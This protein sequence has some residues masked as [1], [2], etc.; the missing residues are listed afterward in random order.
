MENHV[1]ALDEKNL[2][3]IAFAEETIITSSKSHKDIDS[4]LASKKKSGLLESV[5]VIPIK[6][7]TFLSYTEIES[8]LKLKYLKDGKEK[9]KNFPFDIAEERIDFANAIAE[10]LNFKKDIATENKTTPLLKNIG[11]IAFLSLITYVL[12]DAATTLQNGGTI[13]VSGRRSGVKRLFVM[14]ADY[15]GPTGSIIAGVI[16]I[17]IT[18]FFAFK[19]WS[20]PSNTVTYRK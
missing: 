1:Y 15:L 4:L 12:F 14:A 6:D 3:S 11:I 5:K 9:S 7:L 20:N 10:K 13:E 2:K 16:A 17:I 19:R 8:N 18:G